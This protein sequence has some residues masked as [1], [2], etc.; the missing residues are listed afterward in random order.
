MAANKKSETKTGSIPI[1]SGRRRKL[2]FLSRILLMM[3]G[4]VL[5]GVGLEIFL[6]PNS[7]IDGGI[8]GISIMASYLTGLPLSLFLICIN[9]PF[10]Y[11]GYKQIGKTFALSTLFSVLCLAVVVNFLH[12]VPGITHDVFLASIFGGVLLGGGVGLIIRI[13]GS[14]DG[15]EIVAI[16][17]D[18]RTNFSIGEIVM[19]F[20]LFILGTSGFI[21]GWDR[22]MYSLLAYFIAYKV[23]DVVVEGLDESKAVLIITE[24]Y[25]DV[26]QAIADRLGR[27]YTLL[28]STGGYSNQPSNIV[29]VVISRLEVAKLKSIVQGF[30]ANALMTINNVE[31]AG[32]RFAKRAIH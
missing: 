29:Y 22:A 1:H 19:I 23:I 32:R 5:A 6:I 13:G 30:D 2:I 28:P 27:G 26:G 14:L 15:T 9:A 7:L 17:L 4:S 18:R 8:T 31:V 12:P 16:I 20:N 24:K 21:Y 11:I 3:L 25:E 10:L